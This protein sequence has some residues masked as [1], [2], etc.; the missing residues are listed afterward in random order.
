MQSSLVDPLKRSYGALSEQAHNHADMVLAELARYQRMDLSDLMGEIYGSRHRLFYMSVSIGLILFF[1]TATYAWYVQNW[2]YFISLYYSGMTVTSVGY[3]DVNVK[4]NT[5]F[6]LAIVEGFGALVVGSFFSIALVTVIL[7]QDE[8]DAL[9]VVP[10]RTRIY[11][12]I[13]ITSALSIV[14][15]LFVGF[16]EDWDFGRTVFW[17]VDTF[18]TTGNGFVT[19]T[20]QLGRV[21]TVMYM[22]MVSPILVVAVAGAIAYPRALLLEKNR[23]RVHQVAIDTYTDT[24]DPHFTTTTNRD[25]FA[26]KLLIEAHL[27]HPDDVRD[28]FAIYDQLAQSDSTYRP[29]QSSSGP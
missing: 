25:T 28:A 27:V 29:P 18:T 21:G 8:E 3:G 13:C 19:P 4:S 22:L 16:I 24:P 7:T 20:T 17:C 23:A 10:I 6:S 2:T 12:C 9:R 11:K 15:G 14:F 5:W 26:L 1:I